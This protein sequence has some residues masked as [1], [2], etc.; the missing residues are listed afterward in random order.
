MIQLPNPALYYY[1]SIP[2]T[3]DDIEKV[4][5]DSGLVKDDIV[6]VHSDVH[7]FGKLGDIKSRD[8]FIKTIL[9]AFLNVVG[10]NGTLIVPAYSYSFCK[11]EVFDIKNTR[12]T[13]GVFSE[14]VRT[15]ESAVRSEDPIFSHAGI[16]K[17]AKSLLNNVG[18]ECFGKESFFDRIL[19]FDG[20]IINFGKFFDITFIHYIEKEFKVSYRREK[21]FSGTMINVNGKRCHKEFHFYARVPFGNGGNIVYDMALLGN[22]LERKGLLCRVSLGNSYVLCSKVMDCYKVGLEMLSKKEYAFLSKG[23]AEKP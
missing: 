20:K 9:N 5:I 13:V 16:G 18:N 3:A 23:P 22:E 17:H 6:L 12:S 21:K 2:I 4:L 1:N 19:K 10:S 14:F 15:L 7:S 8:I 11:N